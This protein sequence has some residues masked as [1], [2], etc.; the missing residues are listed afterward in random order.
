[1][2]SMA[3][4]TLFAALRSVGNAMT[5]AAG[6]VYLA[7]RS[8]I[9]PGTRKGLAQIS[10]QLTIPALLFSKL[11]ACN[12]DWSDEPCPSISDAL[13]TG[14]LMLLWPIAVVGSGLLVGKLVPFRALSVRMPRP[15]RCARQSGLR[16]SSAF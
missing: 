9:T 10:Q 6:G 15:E 1:M 16:A 14:W 11:L 13:H 12:Q 7:K 5:M 8:L 4:Q 2:T 3:A